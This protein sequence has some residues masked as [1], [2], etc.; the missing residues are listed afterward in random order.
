MNMH[1]VPV[2]DPLLLLSPRRHHELSAIA[3]A[4]GWRMATA[5][6]DGSAR[7]VVLDA[8]EALDDGLAAAPAL[9]DAARVHGGAVL[10]LVSKQDV[11]AL[12][13]FLAAGATH[14]L[15][16]PFGD[17]EFAQAL[18]FAWRH[19]ERLAEQSPGGAPGD[20]SL[21]PDAAR[22]WI[23]QRLNHGEPVGVILVALSRF[24]L[25]NSGYGQAAGD[26]LIHAAERRIAAEAGTVLASDHVVART[27]GPEFLLAFDGGA[28]S[29]TLAQT[30]SASFARPFAIESG[31]VSVGARLGV[32]V[33]RAGESVDALLRRANDALDDARISDGATVRTAD[34]PAIAD[35]LSVDLRRAIDGG[36]IAV[37]FQPQVAIAPGRIVGVEVLARW[38]HPKFGAVGAD[39]L[40]AAADRAD[41]GIAL[42]D[43]IQ[44]LALATAAGWQ[45]P[46]NELRL[47]INLTAADI[48]RPGFVDIFLDRV[49]SVRFPRSRLTVE[50]TESGL[51]DDLG[52]AAQ[53]L[54]DLRDAGC[55]VAIDDFGTGY[56]SLAYLKA[57]PLDYLK[58]DK[59][60]AHD[61]TG[62]V[63]DR[64]VVRG[65]IDMARSLGL[66]VIAEGV[67]TEE[68]LDLLAKEGCQ[69]YQG[70]LCAPPLT[71][72]ALAARIAG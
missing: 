49:D 36:E 63:R 58:I 48:A 34:E 71:V 50:I 32:A 13:T 44:R 37:L 25:V 68:Q 8:R 5:Q 19:V 62:T 3:T 2:G 43:H 53:L 67:E 27:K 41:L 65:V 14:F 15:V 30:L 6:R 23:A 45:A 61:I 10:V 24:D 59:K 38:E 9:G 60:L 55:R 51:I 56:S 31:L 20:H 29:E 72:E 12:D 33:A 4:A 11:V 47:A 35:A 7:L 42:S 1:H 26:A 28:D 18:H 70:F 40:F 64:V 46:L 69:Y 57:L 66:A 17:E 21:D 39:L 54:T 52:A 16:S 22:D